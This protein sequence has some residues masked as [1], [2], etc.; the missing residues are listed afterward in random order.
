M[1][2]IPVPKNVHNP[3]HLTRGEREKARAEIIINTLPSGTFFAMNFLASVIAGYGL[4]QDSPAVVI[5]AMLVAMMLGPIVG[6]GLAVL[7][8]DR[9]QLG[10]ALLS[11]ALGTIWVVAIG[12]GIGMLHSKHI[13]TSE[14]FGRTAPNVMDLMIA[15]AGGL[16]G[17][18]AAVSSRLP[19]AVV[20]VGVATALVPPLVTCGI[21]L[22]RGHWGMASGAFLLTLTNMVAIQFAS[23][24]ILWLVGFRR[25]TETRERVNFFVV[26]L[27]SIVLLIGLGV[28]LTLNLTEASTR[29]RLDATVTE[30]LAQELGTGNNRL[31][32]AKIQL[33]DKTLSENK[34]I[35]VMAY[36][37]GDKA[38]SLA[39]V[40]RAR[41]ALPRLRNLSPFRLQVRFV[42]VEIITAE[43][44]LPKP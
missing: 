38:P 39:D 35:T 16:A 11:I 19:V 22:S 44:D 14:I 4:L 12:Y 5:G 13:L 15:L 32:S 42:P 41:A 34:D 6:L 30:T 27:W 18:L 23:S 28:L 33:P 26:N 25:H 24:V 37:Q 8:R 29:Q 7:E 21:L 17:A 10:N 43:G 20:G 36:V 40:Q 1:S 3:L 2:S 31:I 9:V